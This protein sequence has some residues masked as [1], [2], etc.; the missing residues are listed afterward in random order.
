MRHKTGYPWKLFED[1]P[2]LLFRVVELH[3]FCSKK[4]GTTWPLGDLLVLGSGRR[5][6]EEESLP[7]WEICR[8]HGFSPELSTSYLGGG[9]MV[10][11]LKDKAV[12]IWASFHCG[13]S[14]ASILPQFPWHQHE[15]DLPPSCLFL[16]VWTCEWTCEGF[17]MLLKKAV[18]KYYC[19]TFFFFF[20]SMICCPSSIEFTET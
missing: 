12:W 8:P 6:P 10:W 18:Y 7:F 1:Y 16:G 20:S 4:R 3:S 15:K 14:L 13:Y 19:N 5:Y 9:A 11:W 17:H 2:E